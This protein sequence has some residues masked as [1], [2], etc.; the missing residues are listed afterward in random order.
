MTA[1]GGRDGP[2]RESGAMDSI[3]QGLLGAAI[4]QAGFRKDACRAPLLWG[5]FCGVLPDFDLLVRFAGPWASMK[6]HRAET[7]SLILQTLAAPLL[8]YLGWRICGRSGSRWS[9]MLL[10]WLCL[11]THSLLDWCTTYGTQLFA[12]FSRHTYSLD[13]VFIIDIFY[14]LPLLAVF[15]VALT[16][17]GRGRGARRFAA[18]MLLLTTAYLVTGYV[19]SQRAIAFARA[20]LANGRGTS[21]PPPEV[22]EAVRAIPTFSNI[23]LYR[24]VAKTGN[25][26][27]RSGTA[28]TWTGRVRWDAMA[29]LVQKNVD[30]VLAEDWRFRRLLWFSQGWLTRM[31]ILAGEHQE[32]GGIAATPVSRILFRDYR[33]GLV[34]ARDLGPFAW[35][36]TLTEDLSPNRILEFKRVSSPMRGQGGGGIRAAFGQE[37]REVWARIFE[38]AEDHRGPAM[39]PSEANGPPATEGGG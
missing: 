33:F 32:G 35:E 11:V 8:G 30:P 21:Q 26:K 12:P 15:I 27:V 39:S 28:S 24:V 9:W 1:V 23:L 6:Y 13:A 19:N 14:S 20:D 37:I 16:R 34:T 31:P 7:H 4:G 10:T 3:T 5:G 38:S 29:I 18:A 25:G 36:C 2:D 22:P 17:W